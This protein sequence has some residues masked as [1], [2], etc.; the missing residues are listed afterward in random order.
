MKKILIVFLSIIIAFSLITC[1]KS[2]D[3]SYQAGTYAGE[4]SGFNGLVK[5]EVTLSDNAI[6]EVKVVDHSETAG[7]S[8]SAIKDVPTSILNSQTLNVDVSAGATFT[9]K[10]IIEAT[11]N[12]LKEAGINTDDLQTVGVGIKSEDIVDATY[13]V[14][15]IGAGGA[16]LSAAI[17]AASTGAKVV[18]I[19]K[20]PFAGGNTILSY[21]EIASPGNW[22]QEEQGITDSAELLAK[23][24]Y[25]G[26]GK[27][28]NKEL[29]DIVANN[30][31]DAALWMRDTIGVEY[32][33][34]LVHEG[35]HSVPRAVEP[36]T[37]GP[38]MI[39]PMVDYA[40]KQ[41]VDII[42]NTKAEEF[43][44]DENGRVTGVLVSNGDQTAIMTGTNG[45]V[46]ATGGFGAN[47]EM[48]DKYNTRW[49]TLD[50][51]IPTTNAPS[52]M[53]DGILMAEA[54]GA[55][56]IDMEHIQ[57]YPFNNPKTGTFYSI[58]APSWSSQGMVYINQDGNRF[59]D[60]MGMRDVRAEGIL[61]QENAYALYNQVSADNLDL[62]AKY[63]T[64]YAKTLEDGLFYKADTLEEVAEYFNINEGNLLA[65]METFNTDAKNGVDTE[66]GR[67]DNLIAMEAG[68][69]YMMK[70]VVSV[71]HTMGG[72]EID[73]ETHVINTEGNVI[74]G[75][76]AAGEVVGGIHGNNRVGTCAI[77]DIVVFGRIAGI[78]AAASK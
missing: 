62:E 77:A 22:L 34:Y 44:Q 25:A 63:A 31:L 40:L 49:E 21:A 38:G 29:V 17:K 3:G 8:D 58:E 46:L 70:G 54:V 19:E 76:Y 45:I 59:V 15:V 13:D 28:G 53:G 51:S 69:W 55:N 68:P 18:I 64:E 4:A 57:L 32:Q 75:L 43:V 14:V 74:P 1:S 65:T 47:V 35:G 61:A 2:K 30:A 27:L 78:N 52:I 66:F 23:E 48:R 67:T 20:M 6:T 73:A 41:G 50:A 16:G 71:H 5:V 60:E 7:I 11:A 37:L 39:I 36:I 10:A 12:A 24:M 56:L 72:V 33:D 26:G 42:Y 9:S